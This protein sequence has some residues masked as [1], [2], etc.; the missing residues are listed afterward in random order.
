MNALLNVLGVLIFDT[1][2][3]LF[4]GKPYAPKAV[5]ATVRTLIAS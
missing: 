5:V 2:P 1:L 4:I 3:G